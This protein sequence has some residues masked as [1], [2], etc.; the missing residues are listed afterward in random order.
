MT[1]VGSTRVKYVQ[2]TP[3][4]VKTYVSAWKTFSFLIESVS[5]RF[6]KTAG[7]R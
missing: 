3:L 2:Q 4:K 7:G 1:L 6:R 5:V